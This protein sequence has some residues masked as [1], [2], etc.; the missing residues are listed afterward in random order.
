MAIATVA[1]LAITSAS[2]RYCYCYRFHYCESVDFAFTLR[3][4]FA[5]AHGIAVFAIASDS[6]LS[7]Q[8]KC[9]LRKE[10]STF[11]ALKSNQ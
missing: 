5:I 4:A 1:A 11:N 3:I 2:Y 8:G 7:L 9:F 6:R 10:N